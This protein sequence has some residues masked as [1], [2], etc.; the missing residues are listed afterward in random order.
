LTTASV[1]SCFA[2][3]RAGRPVVAVVTDE[4]AT[5]GHNMARHLGHA[6]LRVLVLPYPLEA[7]RRDE[8]LRISADAY[9]EALAL[10]GVDA[11]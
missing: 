10:L 8:L 11:P 7:R 9:P 4:F 6:D 1:S 5:H 3:Q 2:I